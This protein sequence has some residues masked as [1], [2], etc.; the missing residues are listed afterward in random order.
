M[1]SSNCVLPFCA[2]HEALLTLAK[3]IAQ[4]QE[5]PPETCDG[6]W[7]ETFLE[8]HD[9]KPKGPEAI[10]LDISFPG[11]QLHASHVRKNALSVLKAHP[12]GPAC[13]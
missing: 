11:V 9:S 2:A 5:S 3:T 13:V 7:E 10:S 4:Q 1:L 12:W 6:C 8:H